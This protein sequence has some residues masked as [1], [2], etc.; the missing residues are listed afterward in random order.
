[1]GL[2]GRAAAVAAAAALAVAGCGGSRQQPAAA[3]SGTPFAYDASRPLA[4]EDHGRVNGTAYPIAVHDVSYAVPGAGRVVGYL[5]LPPAG[6]RLAAVIYV[7]GSGGARDDLV[8]P[9]TWLAGRRAVGL[10]ITAPSS[11]AGPA[12]GN[13]TAAQSLARDRRLTVSD[14]VAV[15]RAVDL[16]RTLPQVD[17]G[18]IGYVG[19]SLGA[20]IGA[21]LAGAEPRIRFFGL[22]SG[23]ATPVAAYAAQAPKALR[24]AVRRAL[25]PIDPLRWIAR[26]RPGAIVLEDGRT[27]AVVPRSALL[28]LARAAPKGTPLRW[29]DAGHTLTAAAYS[30]VLDWLAKKLDIRGPAVAGARTGP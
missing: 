19:W 23:G 30:D 25:A 26:G 1:M 9:A 16:L 12:P 24:P 4:F 20:R 15:R 11:A 5:A 21:I 13:L 27:D 14:V 6:K 10:T 29:Y 22:M 7:H 8:V 17:A 18:R 28:A 2:P 3:G